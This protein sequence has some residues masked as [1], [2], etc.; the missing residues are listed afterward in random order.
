MERSRGFGDGDEGI[1][2]LTLGVV[3]FLLRVGW[4]ICLTIVDV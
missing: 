2:K 1:L 3:R 4:I